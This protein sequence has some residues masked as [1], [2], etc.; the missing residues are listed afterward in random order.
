LDL[1]GARYTVHRAAAGSDDFQPISP[2]PIS[3]PTLVDFDFD[4]WTTGRRDDAARAS[5]EQATIPTMRYR[6]CAVNRRGVAGKFSEFVESAPGFLPLDP[7][8]ETT[9]DSPDSIRSASLPD[10]DG[11]PLKAHLSGSARY[12]GG[13]FHFPNGGHVSYPHSDRFNLG[14][15]PGLTV[16]CH[17]CF[18]G[19]SKMPVVVSAGHWRQAGWFLQQI[20]NNWRWHIGGVDCD[21]GRKP[22]LGESTR[23]RA[24]WDGS[25]AQLYQDGTLVADVP[26]RPQ[27]TAWAGPM[28]I[29]QYS[30]GPSADYQ[31]I[32]TVSDVR[33]YA[34]AVGD[35]Q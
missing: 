6:V 24:T 34:R 27:L 32:G 9:K 1:R 17:V 15:G 12:E 29:G 4:I 20:G 13:V 28:M 11:E 10:S 23:L 16:E 35:P 14:S 26:C 8:F 19:D 7:I 33:I 30:G 25:R 18:T 22:K 2:E 3:G 31:V 5:T 21:G